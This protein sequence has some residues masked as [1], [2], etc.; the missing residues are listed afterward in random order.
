MYVW[1]YCKGVTVADYDDFHMHQVWLSGVFSDKPE[2]DEPILVRSD[3]YDCIY[4]YE[5]QILFEGYLG[6]RGIID[7]QFQQHPLLWKF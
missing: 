7:L 5:D 1:T 3:K 4:Y 2:N 6:G